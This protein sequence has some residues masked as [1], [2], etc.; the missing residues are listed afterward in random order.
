V[1][2]SVRVR[3]SKRVIEGDRV[4]TQNKRTTTSSAFKID[5]P[6]RPP[7]PKAPGSCSRS[8]RPFRSSVR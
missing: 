8:D 4:F 6:S 5:P 7:D 3:M 2:V 1:R